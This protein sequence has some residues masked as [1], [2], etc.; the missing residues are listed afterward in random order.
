MRL[1]IAGW[2]GQL[3]QALVARA[4]GRADVTACAVGRPALDLCEPPTVHRNLADVAPDVVINAAAYTAVDKAE[5]EERAAMAL[6]CDGAR[7]LAEAA[8]NRGIPIIHVSTDYVYPGDKTGP[9]VETDAT[10]PRNAYGRSKL[11]GEAAV[12]AANPR[13]VI[14]RTAWVFSEGGHNFVRTMLRLAGTH[15]EVRVVDDQ[16][17]SP[18]YA[19]HLADAI[20]ELA[21]QLSVAHSASPLT[22]DDPRFGIFNAAGGG[23]VS[24]RGFAEAVFERSRTAGGP[25]AGVIPIPT[26]EYPTPAHRPANSV[27]DCSK[28]QTVYGVSLPAWEM[29]LDACIDALHAADG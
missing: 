4:V 20:L 13:H 9:Y 5:T 12:V 7:L 1:M 3:A 17:G 14:L 6:N 2:Q 28:L 27:L 22:F 18:T 21:A 23:A 16:V 15:E 11:A 24:W 25:A 10:G 29:G 19:P 26:S 8:A